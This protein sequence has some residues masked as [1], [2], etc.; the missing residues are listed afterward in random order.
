MDILWRLRSM[1]WRSLISVTSAPSM[2]ICPA[3][4]S[5]SR[6]MQRTRVDLP[7]PERPMT[8][9]VSPCCT[10]VAGA[11]LHLLARQR[12]IEV[13]QDALRVAPEHLPQVAA[14]DQSSPQ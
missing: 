7:L 9:K 5:T 11:L 12:G 1:S 2:T 8:T 10:S 13:A 14:A 4:G 6:E 3:V